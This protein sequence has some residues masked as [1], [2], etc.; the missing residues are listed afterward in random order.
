M[1]TPM[2]DAMI[3]TRPRKAAPKKIAVKNTI[4]IRRM[5]LSILCTLRP[6]HLPRLAGIELLDEA[7]AVLVLALVCKL[8][9]LCI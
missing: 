7:V 2:V 4:A 1:M 8:Q 3:A 6:V 5:T 9:E